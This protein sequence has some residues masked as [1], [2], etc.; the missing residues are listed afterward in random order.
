MSP[1]APPSSKGNQEEQ[2][3]QPIRNKGTMKIDLDW[4]ESFGNRQ[5]EIISWLVSTL[6]AFQRKC[7]VDNI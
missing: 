3:I 4:P 7:E 6:A 5:V 1:K 2:K